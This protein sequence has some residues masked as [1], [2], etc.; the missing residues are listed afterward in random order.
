MK[1]GVL[2]ET[3][4][5]C[6]WKRVCSLTNAVVT[7]KTIGPTFPVN[8]V[9]TARLN[10]RIVLHALAVIG[11]P[12]V[13]D[14]ATADDTFARNRFCGRFSFC[15]DGS[16]VAA[17]DAGRAA[18]ARTTPPRGRGISKSTC[19]PPPGRTCHYKLFNNTTRT[20]VNYTRP[21]RRA[22]GF[23]KFAGRARNPEDAATASPRTL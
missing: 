17:F 23:A 4:Y 19:E 14:T 2:N 11:I 8:S 22:L 12:C 16:R 5:S 1:S 7:A 6:L 9:R 20:T 21:P 18:P 10:H 13:V 15:L 3:P